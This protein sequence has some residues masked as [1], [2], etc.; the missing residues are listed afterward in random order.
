VIPLC[1]TCRVGLGLE[2]WSRLATRSLRHRTFCKKRRAR[3]LPNSSVRRHNAGSLPWRGFGAMGRS[4]HSIA[5]ARGRRAAG[6][7]QPATGRIA[8]MFIYARSREVRN[9]ST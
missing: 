9:C 6:H 3:G 1:V 7:Q 8:K 2:V 5:D 4:A